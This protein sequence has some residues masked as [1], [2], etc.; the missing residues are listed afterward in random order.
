MIVHLVEYLALSRDELKET[1]GRLLAANEVLNGEAVIDHLVDEHAS[2]IF[3]RLDY[4]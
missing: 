3:V 1:L 4:R 2:S